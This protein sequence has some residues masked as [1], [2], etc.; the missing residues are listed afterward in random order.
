MCCKRSYDSLTVV[1]AATSLAACSGHW[2]LRAERPE[3][4]AAL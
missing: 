1:G 2:L 3:F 4:S